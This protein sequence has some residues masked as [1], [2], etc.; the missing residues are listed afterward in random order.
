MVATVMGFFKAPCVGKRL[1]VSRF[2][3]IKALVIFYGQ[4]NKYIE[5]NEVSTLDACLC[6]P[7]D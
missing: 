3:K 4:P 6:C 1:L 5:P 7:F 2:I